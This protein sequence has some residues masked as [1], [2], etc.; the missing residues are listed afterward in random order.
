MSHALRIL[1]YL[2]YII[3]FRLTIT[4][5]KRRKYLLRYGYHCLLMMFT[6]SNFY[7]SRT[8]A[9]IIYLFSVF[10]IHPANLYCHGDRLH[11]LIRLFPTSLILTTIDLWSRNPHITSSMFIYTST[12]G[13]GW[14]HQTQTHTLPTCVC[15]WRE[16]INRL[17]HVARRLKLARKTFCHLLCPLPG[18]NWRKMTFL[19]CWWSVF[20]KLK[21]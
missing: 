19:K 1:N 5:M 10:Q 12:P 14:K 2:K 9:N 13:H 7:I 18:W 6:C 17:I 21:W 3:E 15:M 16:T 20:P 8:I 11:N 4:L